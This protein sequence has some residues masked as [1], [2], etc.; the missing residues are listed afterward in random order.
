MKKFKVRKQIEFKTINDIRQ[1]LQNG[2]DVEQQQN[3]SHEIQEKYKKFKLY[4]GEKQKNLY[5]KTIEALQDEILEELKGNEISEESEESEELEGGNVSSGGEYVFPSLKAWDRSKFKNETVFKEGDNILS[6][7]INPYHRYEGENPILENDPDFRIPVLHADQRKNIFLHVKFKNTDNQRKVLTYD[8]TNHRFLFPYVTRTQ[9][10][11]KVNA[12]FVYT[13]SNPRTEIFLHLRATKEIK[14]GEYIYALYDGNVTDGKVTVTDKHLTLESKAIER[15]QC[16]E[17]KRTGACAD[18]ADNY[19]QPPTTESA[20]VATRERTS[21]AGVATG[22][23]SAGVA[24]R[25]TSAGVATRS[26]AGAASK[27]TSAGVATGSTSA[28][29][30]RRVTRSTPAGT[31]KRGST[32]PGVVTKKT[33]K[34]RQGRRP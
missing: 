2:M 30:P 9:N 6:M 21:S 10:Q 25:G 5:D 27:S 29:V 28:E 11:D 7:H 32:P 23:T 22:S 3:R 8:F 31:K 26:S 4:Y 16:S 17:I 13:R 33:G 1:L 24:R 20:N 15:P 12:E 14:N 18:L 19:Q 34:G